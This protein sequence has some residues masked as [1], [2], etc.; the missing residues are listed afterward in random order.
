MT[1]QYV[2]H[3]ERS[4]HHYCQSC[5]EPLTLPGG[6]AG[7]YC[8]GCRQG[9]PVQA[10]A[11]AVRRCATCRVLMPKGMYPPQA[12][13][14]IECKWAADRAARREA[15]NIDAAFKSAYLKH[16]DLAGKHVMVTM[17]RVEIE[18]VGQGQ[19][20]ETKPVLYFK[21]HER[22]LVLNKT[23]AGS[24]A[25]IVGTK[26]TDAWQGHRIVL[27]PTKTDFGG[28]RVDC[29]RIAAP[30]NGTPRPTPPPPPAEPEIVEGFSVQDEDVPF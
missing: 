29:I 14:C 8:H 17:D 21:G 22:A 1:D 11:I 30:P 3:D 7:L 19:D 4:E 13:L 2:C 6:P 10:P 23:N 5:G 27:Y 9:A 24:I 16:S 12:V 25:E 18:T 15:M 28:K 20:Q 26:E